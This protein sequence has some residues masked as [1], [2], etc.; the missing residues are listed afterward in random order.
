MDYQ[1]FI[2]Y[3]RDGGEALAYLIYERLTQEGYNVFLD[4]ESLRSGNFNTALYNRIEE[5]TDFLLILPPH[6]LDRCTNTTDWVRMEIEHAIE[7]RKNIIPIMMRNFEFPQNL[8]ETL[9]EVPNFNGISA[10]MELFDGVLIKLK[11][12]F[13]KSKPVKQ[14]QVNDSISNEEYISFDERLKN[15]FEE[16]FGIDSEVHEISPL[17]KK[18]REKKIQTFIETLRADINKGGN[19]QSELSKEQKISLIPI[20]YGKFD[21]CCMGKHFSIPNRDGIKTLVYEVYE[22]IDRKT[23]T[24][25]YDVELVDSSEEQSEENM[26]V[27]TYYIDDVQDDGNQLVFLHFDTGSNTVYVNTGLLI[28]NSVKIT[29]N[30][31]LVS[32]ENI[33]EE[34]LDLNGTAYDCESIDDYTKNKQYAYCEADIDSNPVIIIDPE[35]AKPVKREIYY[36]EKLNCYKA[37]IKVIPGK[38]YFA[39][40]IRD[41]DQV[42]VPLTNIEKAEFYRKGS[43]GFTKNAELAA[44]LCEE[45]GTAEAIYMAAQ[46]VKEELQ[47]NEMYI[48]YLQKAVDMNS[49]SAQLELALWKYMHG[50]KYSFDDIYSL[51]KK[52]SENGLESGCFIYA[53]CLEKGLLCEKD[54]NA[55]FEL[56]YNAAREMYNP[57]LVRLGLNGSGGDIQ[58]KESLYQYFSNEASANSGIAEYCL[59]AVLIFGL[60]VQPAKKEGLCLLKKAVVLGNIDAIHVLLEIYKVEKSFFDDTE[61]SKFLQML[62][63][64]EGTI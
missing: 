61:I 13:L 17:A 56:Y 63:E 47:D 18:I 27:T 32:Y 53:Y 21:A 15:R 8:P 34:D 16:L 50:D 59:G 5:C 26:V 57:A 54:I 64:Y 12:Q 51:L 22:N 45:D 29:T 58:N 9:K 33:L 60:K 41:D 14:T 35:T 31:S 42:Y 4:V 20:E 38:P 10:N 44:Q 1:V 52:S 11:N 6:A 7:C 43:R 23:L 28:N 49:S 46:I 37:K 39:F 30:P 3:R 40:Q 62:T 55:A 48:E 2:S 25:Y 19:E 24:K 36:D